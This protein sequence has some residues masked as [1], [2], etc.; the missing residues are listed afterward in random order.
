MSIICTIAYNPTSLIHPE[1]IIPSI[2]LWN[3]FDTLQEKKQL[4]L[5]VNVA[6]RVGAQVIDAVL[7]PKEN[8]ALRESATKKQKGEH[9]QFNMGFNPW[10]TVQERGGSNKHARS[11]SYKNHQSSDTN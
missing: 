8:L 1:E 5:A 10:N 11:W 3:T 6:I 2:H 9:S 7:V 4:I